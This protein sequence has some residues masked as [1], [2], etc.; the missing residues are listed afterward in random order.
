MTANNIG[1]TICVAGMRG[2]LGQDAGSSTEIANL[3]SPRS[4][5]IIKR[6]VYEALFQSLAE[7]TQDF[8]DGVAH[9]VEKRSP[10]F[11]GRQASA[12]T[13]GARSLRRACGRDHAPVP[14]QAP[15]DGLADGAAGRRG[16]E[17][18]GCA[19]LE[20]PQSE[21]G[22]RLVLQPGESHA[23]SILA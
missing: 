11:T 4:T 9:D 14:H 20:P 3:S 15:V 1:H 13:R 19:R 23:Q 2:R 12:A 8:R 22:Q 7:A 6:Q 10:N 5:R 16:Y 18:P 21:K 17:K